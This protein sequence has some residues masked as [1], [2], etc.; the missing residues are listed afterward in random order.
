MYILDWE[1]STKEIHATCTSQLQYPLYMWW[2]L[3]SV[4]HT[5]KKKFIIILLHSAFV[6]IPDF[7]NAWLEKKKIFII[8][9]LHSAFLLIHDFSNKNIFVILLLHSAF[10]LMHDFSNKRNFIVI[11]V[12]AVRCW[13][14]MFCYFFWRVQYKIR[15]HLNRMHQMDW[16]SFLINQVIWPHQDIWFGL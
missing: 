6:L 7:S 5:G 16:P 13:F 1:V 12:F 14:L 10:L 8:I 3:I 4:T 15:H 11:F 9:L 2:W